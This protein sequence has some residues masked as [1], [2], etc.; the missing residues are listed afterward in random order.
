M[1]DIKRNLEIRRENLIF[2]LKNKREHL[3]LE[4]QHQIYGAIKE[5]DYIMRM[6]EHL[7]EEEN[8][9]RNRIMIKDESSE[10][11]EAFHKIGQRVRAFKSPIR[12]RFQKE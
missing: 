3:E 2:L 8:M 9:S 4:K 5:I 7:P 12:I 1:D 11:V 10:S 6:I